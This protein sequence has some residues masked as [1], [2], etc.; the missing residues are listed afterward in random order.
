MD[1]L[2]WIFVYCEIFHIYHHSASGWFGRSVSG[3][4]CELFKKYCGTL[5]KCVD[6][7]DKDM[8]HLQTKIWQS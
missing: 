6:G 2:I 8:C 3:L 7:A 1:L 5:R 4:S